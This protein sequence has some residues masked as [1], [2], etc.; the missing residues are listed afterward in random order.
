MYTRLF[1]ESGLS[2]D[3]LRAL[4]EVGAYGSIVRA[5]GGDPVR[6]SQYSRQ[7]KELEDFF[8]A[9]LVERQGRGIRL[10]ARGR[11]LARI[12]RFFLLG[13]SNFQ[14]GCLAEAQSYRLGSSA[15]FAASFLVPFLA[16][17]ASKRQSVQFLLQPA[18]EAEMERGLQ[19][20]TLD[21]AF[22]MRNPLS[23][24]LQQRNLGS[25]TLGFWVPKSLANSE[26][27]AMRALGSKSLPLAWPKDEIDKERFPV[28]SRIEPALVCSSFVEARSLVEGGSFAAV[29]PS[30]LR[31]EP[32]GRFLRLP[33]PEVDACS[34]EYYLAWNPR[35]LRLNPHAE[36]RRKALLLALKKESS[37]PPAD[38]EK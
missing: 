24:P 3:R 6:Q 29:L 32:S 15:T 27:I 14:R 16:H 9:G 17:A 33:L 38:S 34:L 19:D 26:A 35:L 11:E 13:L 20:L 37:P 12:S 36:T 22:V 18:E 7:L 10:T 4:V 1:A 31:P 5:A 21:F 23:R 30:F 2:L 25:W 8:Q 28:F